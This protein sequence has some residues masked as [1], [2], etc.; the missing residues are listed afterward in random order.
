LNERSGFSRRLATGDGLKTVDSDV[1]A[2]VAKAMADDP[3]DRYTSVEALLRDLK[4]FR[5]RRPVSAQPSTYFYRLSILVR[6]NALPLTT[7]TVVAAALV[8]FGF[9]EAQLRRE[10]AKEAETAQ[11]VST[12]LA[13]VFEI[14]DPTATRGE[15]VTARELL[16]SGAARIGDDLADQPQVAARLMETMADAYRSLGL[17]AAARDLYERAQTAQKQAGLGASLQAVKVMTKIGDVR[18]T[19]REPDLGEAILLE[20]IALAEDHDRAGQLAL[21]EALTALTRSYLRQHRFDE[22]EPLVRRRMALYESELGTSSAEYGEALWDLS[23]MHSRLSQ[24]ADAERTLLQ[25][26][27]IL[28]RAWGSDDPRLGRAYQNL[29]AVYGMTRR[30]DEAEQTL[31]RSIDLTTKTY[32]AE[33]VQVGLGLM[34]LGHVQLKQR[35]FEAAK[36]TLGRARTI[37]EN[38]Y[39]QNDVRAAV[40]TGL[41]GRAL[42]QNGELERAEA[43]TKSALAKLGER[44]QNN[45]SYIALN[46]RLLA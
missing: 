7:A 30:Y 26:I 35:R 38:G 46:I 11:Q 22:V 13:S 9:R 5:A 18:R 44:T 42:E 3:A 39:G 17:Y 45:S 6:R 36:P 29:A 16:D 12:F 33:H 31:I 14:A 1:R 20:A 32:G 4:N 28:E 34:T 40:A 10:A 15:S 43:E 24:L 19:L 21:A 8:A 27:A 2:I 25:A 41:L 23:H 37:F